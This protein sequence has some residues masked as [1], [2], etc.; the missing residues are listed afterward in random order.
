MFSDEEDGLP[1]LPDIMEEED[2]LLV[3]PGE[4]EFEEEKDTAPLDGEA[5]KPLGQV[6][7]DLELEEYEEARFFYEQ[8]IYSECIEIFKNLLSAHP[9][10]PLLLAQVEDCR[11]KQAEEELHKSGIGA[12]IA[13]DTKKSSTPLKTEKIEKKDE[14]ADG[15]IDLSEEILSNLDM[16]FPTEAPVPTPEATATPVSDS[17][18]VDTHLNLGLAYREMGMLDEAIGEFLTAE[19][20]S[21]SIRTLALLGL[22]YLQKQNKIK[23]LEFFKKALSDNALTRNELKSIR[24]DIGSCYMTA[25]LPEAALRQFSILSELDS[26]YRDVS[27]RIEQLEVL[28]IKAASPDELDKLLDKINLDKLKEGSDQNNSNI[29]YL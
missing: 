13:A 28:E 1:P 2:E 18:T 7:S 26:D 14:P 16:A 12:P 29:S 23:T 10:H 19:K 5:S 4:I 6:L 25:N 24:Y 11:K 17:D 20:K 9:K 21:S 3:D 8:A 22:C 15:S 27:E